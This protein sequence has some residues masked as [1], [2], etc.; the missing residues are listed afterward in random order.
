MSSKRR[1]KEAPLGF[2]EHL[3]KKTQHIICLLIL[4]ILPTIL[5]HQTIW[6]NKE[7]AASDIVQWRAGSQA[8][9]QAR[10]KYHEEPLWDTNMFSGMPAYVI[11]FEKA[12]PN[13]DTLIFKIFGNIFPAG[14]FWVLLFGLY[15]FFVIQDIKPLSATLGA[16]AIG[17]TTYIPIIIG[18]GHNTKFVAFCFIPWVMAGYWL[19]T[20]REKH[21]LIHFFFFALALTLEL[22]ANHPQVTYYFLYLLGFWW[23]FDTYKAYK[24]NEIGEWSK[25]TLFIVGAGIL[26]ILAN[27]QPFWSVFQYSKYSTRGSSAIS[28]S[29][30][31]NL[32]YA[33]SWSQ[34]WGE[35]LTLIIPGLY[36]GSSTT[37]TYWGPKP[38]TSGPHYLG[39]ITFILLIIGIV[40]SKRSLKSLFL[41]VGTLTLLFSLGNHFLLLNK[42]MFEYVPFFNKFRTPEMWLMVTVFCYSV[43]AIYGLEWI[44]T[45]TQEKIASRS[46]KDLYGPMGFVLLIAIIFAFGSSSL[47][48][49][50]KSGERQMIAQ[51]VALQ[52]HVSPHDQRVQQVVSR[53][54]QEKLIPARQAKAKRDSIR[55]LILVIIAGGLIMAAYMKKIPAS[56]AALGLVVLAAYDMLS[57][58]ARYYDPSSLVPNTYNRK[59]VVEQQRTPMDSFLE[60]HVKTGQGWSYRVFPLNQ[61]PFKNAIPAYFYPTIGGYTGAKLGIYQDLINDALM[62]GPS[63]INLGILD[64]LNVKYI[65]NNQVMNMPDLK[66]VYQG[67]NGVVMENENVLPKAFYVDSLKYVNSAKAAL[68]DI[69]TNF[70]PS[71]VAVVETNKQ[72]SVSPDS[73]ATVSVTT[74]RP[75]KIALKTDRS[76]DGFLAL[77]EIYYPA[78][79]KAFIDGKQVPIIKTDFVLR[80]LAVPKGQHT[81]TLTFNPKSYT[82]GK[83]FAWG[84]TIAIYLFGLVGLIGFIQEKQNANE[85]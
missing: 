23:L 34:G 64:M 26:A 57:V 81:I 4:I 8:V 36:G 30:G 83:T 41:F 53:Y 2:W 38:F 61:N 19:M 31:L 12:V 59:M 48:S 5:F 21:K 82:L 1:E 11:N 25:L 7:F 44:I 69:K 29:S 60:K 78:G 66:K 49:F 56:Y 15:F 14:P 42:F 20:R 50:Q 76:T 75:R 62:T 73:S 24:K 51:Q 35:L 43:V 70:H 77:S 85:A 84:G 33:M 67:K 74:Y 6:G 39:A 22:R 68:N 54:L 18:A 10:K 37:G 58:G 3:P 46:L 16:I 13:I 55:F 65:T 45:K 72:I 32:S 9:M 52:N 80:G 27:A 17:F 63:G 47:F 28:K 71:K 40:K 79:W